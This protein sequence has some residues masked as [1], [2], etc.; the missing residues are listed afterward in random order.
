[1]L[2]RVVCAITLASSF[3]FA[4][5]A[6][7]AVKTKVLVLQPARALNLERGVRVAVVPFAYSWRGG[8]GQEGEDLVADML[9]SALSDIVVDGENY[10]D[11]LDRSSTLGII[12]QEQNL[13]SGDLVDASTLPDLGGVL[14][15]QYV[16]G[17]N[18]RY[19]V[20]ET[21]RT[22]SWDRC[23]TKDKDGNCTTTRTTSLS[24]QILEVAVA[25]FPKVSEVKTSRIKYKSK[26]DK[27]L[28]ENSCYGSTWLGR[29]LII[30]PWSYTSGSKVY[31][32][33]DPLE[34]A[35]KALSRAVG[36]FIKDVAPYEEKIE[37]Y[38][39]GGGS[40]KSLDKA[41]RKAAKKKFKFAKKQLK[42]NLEEGCKVY[43]DLEDELGTIDINLSFNLAVCSEFRGNYDLAAKHYAEVAATYRRDMKRQPKWLRN[44]IARLDVRVERYKK[45]LKQL[46]VSDTAA[47]DWE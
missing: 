23:R 34:L 10:F 21:W 33:I 9:T 15:A 17:G 3:L 2:L 40:F 29:A 16:V 36:E 44:A 18:S 46:E 1:M 37:L 6:A 12:E 43:D 20:R 30:D 22:Y 7:E 25:F 45:L 32:K 31:S 13:R 27:D 4:S 14:G 19:T 47:D 5:P 28:K 39:R 38:L 24:C 35:N 42:R 41:Q 8:W 26:I 11:V